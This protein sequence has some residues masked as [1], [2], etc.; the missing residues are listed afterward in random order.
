MG[1]CIIDEINKIVHR[2]D[3]LWHLGDFAWK[4]AGIW[5]KKIRCKNVNLIWGNHDKKSN[6]K[7]FSR[8]LDTF[9]Q[10]I[11]PDNDKQKC[12]LSH[13]PHAYWPASH[14]GSMHLYGHCHG[15][16]EQT[17]DTLFPGRRSMDVGVDEAFR[18]FGSY[19]PFTE[20][21]VYEILIEGNSMNHHDPIEF[22]K[23][24]QNVHK[25]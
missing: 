2:G 14:H 25:S 7:Y 9:I 23:E 3:T 24:Y 1:E 18:R 10:K 22:Y 4:D 16:R 20:D 8:T 15:Q 19:R 5:R 13:Y 17:L 6:A 12:F 11:G 21:E